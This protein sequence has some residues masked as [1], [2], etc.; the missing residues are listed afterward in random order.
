MKKQ[1]TESKH[2]SKIFSFMQFSIIFVAILTSFMTTSCSND[3]DP[4][5]SDALCGTW[6][7]EDSYEGDDYYDNVKIT[8]K[9]NKDKTGS[10]V[11][12]WYWKTRAS[13]Q[14]HYSMNFSWS[15]TKDDSGEVYLNVS[16]ISGDKDTKLFK[17]DYVLW[18]RKYVLTGKI[19]NIYG[20]D[21]SNSV[22]VF[23]KK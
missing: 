15:T 16:Y 12:D 3:D 14:E 22:W 4:S 11:E 21:G 13:E 5:S 6:I 19:L 23:N 17:G 10:I 18:K 8:L 20:N 9:F 1:T 7:Y 2:L